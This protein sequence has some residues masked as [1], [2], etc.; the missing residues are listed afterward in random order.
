MDVGWMHFVLITKT[1]FGCAFG[2]HS[3]RNAADLVPIALCEQT[4]F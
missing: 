1:K 4:V 3:K 2:C